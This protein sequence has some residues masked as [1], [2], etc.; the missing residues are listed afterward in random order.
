MFQ[1]VL[2]FFSGEGRDF[3]HVPPFRNEVKNEWSYT[4]APNVTFMDL[5][6]TIFLYLNNLGH[7]ACIKIRET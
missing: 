5:T 6:R 2:G 3:D 4:S 7:V 1:W